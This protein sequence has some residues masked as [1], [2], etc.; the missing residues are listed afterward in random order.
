MH[1]HTHTH[2][3]NIYFGSNADHGKMFLGS[4]FYENLWKSP[5]YGYSIGCI[6]KSIDSLIKRSKYVVS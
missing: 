6:D 3:T 1:T 2:T 5:L 4:I